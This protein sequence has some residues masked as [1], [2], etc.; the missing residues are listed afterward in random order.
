M[1]YAELHAL[2]NF[3]F[4]E[5]ASHPDELVGQAK[6]LGL[7][8]LAITDRNTLAGVV[9]AHVA[10]KA[11][12]LRLIIGARLDFE[13][14]PSIVCLP[15][16]RAAYG[17]LCR[18]LSLGQGRAVKAQCHLKL[19]DLE[20]HSDGQLLIVLPPA[21]WEW[22]T[23]Q[24]EGRAPFEADVCRIT[25][26]ARAARIYLAATLT[27]EGADR[28]RFTALAHLGKRAGVALV[29]TNA[30]RFHSPQRRRLADVL[31]CIKSGTVIKQAGYL[32]EA[33]AERHLKSPAAMA[34]LFK[35]HTDA[36]RVR[37]KW[38]VW[39]GFRSMNWS[40]NIQTSRFRAGARP[41]P[42]SRN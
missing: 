34:R 22:R 2:S 20:S 26:V 13:D 23:D 19:A 9:R 17:R 37:W 30:V 25:Q 36:W 32:L 3:S 5:G 31:A 7:A 12:G 10:A 38:L 41:M 39:P 29:A 14:G 21:Q 16:D 1:A 24:R 18:L 4:L 28:A 42:I 35:G 15:T 8:A 27:Y 6:A 40:M 11:V 33:N